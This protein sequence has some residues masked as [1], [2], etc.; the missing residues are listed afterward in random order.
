VLLVSSSAI[1]V[2]K[3]TRGYAEIPNSLIENQ[4][5]LTRAEL[6]LALIVLRRGNRPVSDAN[7][8]AWTGLK[9]RMKEAAAAGLRA[10]CLKIDG[11]GDSAQYA[12]D[13]QTWESFVKT[14]DRAEKPR[15]VG[16]AVDPKPGAKI[17]QACRDN[18][19]QMLCDASQKCE[20]P[21]FA[22]PNAQR[23]A[24]IDKAPSF[25]TP[26]PK[27]TV[28]SE[29]PSI[30]TPN[31]QRVARNVAESDFPLT[32]ASVREAYP[33]VG[34]DFLGRLVERVSGPHGVVTDAELCKAVG[35]A[36]AAN[37][38]KQK[39]EGLFLLTVPEA[40]AVLRSSGSKQKTAAWQAEGAHV[41][42]ERRALLDGMQSRLSELGAPFADV[43]R[44]VREFGSQVAEDWSA[45]EF[46][47]GVEDL[48]SEIAKVGAAALADSERVSLDMQIMADLHQYRAR[49]SAPQFAELKAQSFRRAVLQRYGMAR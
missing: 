38:R 35:M 11:R 27:S 29:S 5:L 6:A 34:V 10:K 12:F 49:M 13:F 23:V 30:A 37:H 40:L 16:R 42:A 31:A 18:G 39:S 14:S 21:A 24:Q 4:A 43:S 3:V 1:F 47:D 45:S 17:H 48:E 28:K 44:R 19:C 22:T 32:M 20:T 36:W 2:P 25:A 8:Q 46:A 9:P 33:L 15:T 7:W 26:S 41:F